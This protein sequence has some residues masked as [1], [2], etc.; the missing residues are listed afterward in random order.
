M[1]RISASISSSFFRASV[2]MF[3]LSYVEV[4]PRRQLAQFARP[5]WRVRGAWIALLLTPCAAGSFGKHT[6]VRNLHARSRNFCVN[7]DQAHL[8]EEIVLGVRTDNEMVG[9]LV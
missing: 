3:E 6:S 8:P 9:G 2:A 5:A 7:D 4:E 1:R